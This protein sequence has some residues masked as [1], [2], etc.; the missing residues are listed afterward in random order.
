[1]EK[2]LTTQKTNYNFNKYGYI[3]FVMAGIAF[4]FLKEWSNVII[5]IG[6][7]LVFDPFDTK[8]PFPK[9]PLWQRLILLAHLV[10]VLAAVIMEIFI[11]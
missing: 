2:E 1:M 3:A 10:I 11:K 6:L 4:L 7:A 8:L 9:R 5:F